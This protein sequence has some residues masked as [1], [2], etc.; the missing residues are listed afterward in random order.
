MA[1]YDPVRDMLS[2]P[3]RADAD[4]APSD[5]GPVA[6]AA[7]DPTRA[8][9]GERSTTPAG[10][11][12]DAA[13]QHAPK[14]YMPSWR[15]SPADSVQHA[16]SRAEVAEM[17]AQSLNPLR[18]RP[19]RADV[20]APITKTEKRVADTDPMHGQ[21]A[22]HYN[23]RREVGR[24]AREFS[25]I[26]PLKRFNNWIK[27]SLIVMHSQRSATPGRGARILDMGC[28][29]G[30]D[31]KKWDRQRPELLVMIDIAE[32]SIQQARDRYQAGS[33]RWAAEFF[34]FDC[35]KRPLADVVPASTLQ[36][37]FDTVTMQF[38]LHYGWDTE[39]HARE[40]LSNVAKWLRAGG[41]FIGTIPDSDTIY[42]RLGAQPDPASLS[43]GNEDYQVEFGVRPVPGAK[44]FGN[45]YLF[46][47]EDAVDNV[48]E[49]VVE[50][51][52]FEQLAREY[53]LRLKYKARFDQVL[54]DGYANRALRSLLERMHVID[55]DAA[56]SGV[57]TPNMPP[58]LW[59]ACTL[60]LAF[61]FEKVS[62]EGRKRGEDSPTL[63]P[64]SSGPAEAA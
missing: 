14:P 18:K 9:A 39:T 21:V 49:Y 56:A 24:D 1:R 29:K 48:P 63:R 28:G 2:S 23:K 25:P 64:V 19:D 26:I 34:A 27:S 53:G 57:V 20:R 38:C 32:V 54:A 17:R 47:L 41:T 11:A 7:S 60:Y 58:P 36:T 31:L 30:G 62:E 55:P 33:H 13:P 45:K 37:P 3:R 51:D 40:M 8:A 10:A 52:T 4:T 16:I 15:I 46:W 43:F 6:A 50:W 12:P 59:D 22:H 42:A 61:A 44:P 35:F 5:T